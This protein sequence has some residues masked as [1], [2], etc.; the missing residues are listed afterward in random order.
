MLITTLRTRL[1]IIPTRS[2]ISIH[3]FPLFSNFSTTIEKTD[4]QREHRW[5]YRNKESSST[6]KNNIGE[7]NRGCKNVAKFFFRQREE[8]CQFR[9]DGKNLSLYSL[10]AILL[11]K[12]QELT[13]GLTGY[14]WM[15]SSL[16]CCSFLNLSREI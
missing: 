9:T 6:C 4:T 8:F 10:N 1:Q 11:D 12:C 13:I 7:P 16:F 2:I 3:V 15:I 5:L 14:L